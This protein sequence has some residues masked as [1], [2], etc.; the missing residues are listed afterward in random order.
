MARSV[1]VPFGA[2]AVEYADACDVDAEDWGYLVTEI[3]RR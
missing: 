1:S 3:V 2:L